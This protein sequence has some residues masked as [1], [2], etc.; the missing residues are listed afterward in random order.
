LPLQS[1]IKFEAPG[2]SFTSTLIGLFEKG[3]RY[4]TVFDLGCAD[5]QFFLEH[6]AI[7][8]LPEA[9]PVN[10]DPNPVYEPS[11]KAIKEAVGGHYLIAAV[12]DREGEVE[13]T[14]SVHPYWNSL[15][16]QEHSYWDAIRHLHHDGQTSVKVPAVT[17][18]AVAKR[19]NLM[20]PFLIK[21]DVQGHE[22][23]AL[24][25]ARAVLEQTSVVICEAGL[26]EFA[27]INRTM[28][29]AGFDLFDLTQMNWLNDRSLC[30]FYPVYL[31]R[32]L[33]DLRTPPDWQTMVGEQTV[34]LQVQR[35]A[36]ILRQ[37]DLILQ[38]LKALRNQRKSPVG[39]A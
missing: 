20:P 11:L 8:A 37:N 3:A 29:D 2:G 32:R 36:A 18:D 19:L 14:T 5:G 38:H 22:V 31:S 9:V 23:N 27:A 13:M 1:S 21:L 10:I 6:A 39:A 12:S 16:P 26:D 25:G 35:R 4:S 17:L 28:L 30:W 24:R 33:P 15:C 34:E 7:G